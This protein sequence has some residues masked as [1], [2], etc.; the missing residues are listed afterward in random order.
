MELNANEKV[1]PTAQ[2]PDMSRIHFPNEVGS[3]AEEAVAIKTLHRSDELDSNPFIEY[4]LAISRS[5]SIMDTEPE[6]ALTCRW[7]VKASRH[8]LEFSSSSESDFG[9]IA[10]EEAVES[11]RLFPYPVEMPSRETSHSLILAKSIRSKD[12]T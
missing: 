3:D 12:R 7:R 9:S 1:L 6:P 10:F 8:P 11:K 4:P 5:N 2:P